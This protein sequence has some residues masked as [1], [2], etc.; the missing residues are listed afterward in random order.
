MQ[1]FTNSFQFLIGTVLRVARGRWESFRPK[2]Q[3][4]IGTVLLMLIR[5]YGGC[6]GT[7]Q[8]L[9]GTVLQQYFRHFPALSSFFVSNLFK[10]SV[11]LTFLL[12]QISL[13]NQ[14]FFK[15]IFFRLGRQTFLRFFKIF[16]AFSSVFSYFDC[17]FSQYFQGF[18]GRQ[19]F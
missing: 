9:I 11:D 15:K 10:K 18:Q 16:I 5:A 12:S 1:T 13:K 4:L 19:T 6:L 2:F 17:R 7:F 3:F 14:A 8:F